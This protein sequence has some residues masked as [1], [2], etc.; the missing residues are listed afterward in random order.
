MKQKQTYTENRVVALRGDGG[1]GECE[2]GK[3]KQQYDDRWKP[4]FWW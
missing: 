2:I 3:G 4:K 1:W